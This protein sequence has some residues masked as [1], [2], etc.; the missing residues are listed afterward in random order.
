M[1]ETLGFF[2]PRDGEVTPFTEQ[3]LFEGIKNFQ[4]ENGLY[5]T[6]E[7]RPGDPTV[8]KLREQLAG[9]DSATGEAKEPLEASVGAGGT[10]NAVDLDTVKKS[11][12]RAG[13][14]ADTNFG[15][16]PKLNNAIRAFQANVGLIPDGVINPGSE[17]AELLADAAEVGQREQV[18]LRMSAGKAD[19][20]KPPKAEVRSETPSVGDGKRASDRQNEVN[21]ETAIQSRRTDDVGKRPEQLFRIF[22]LNQKRLHDLAPDQKEQLVGLLHEI[23]DA[24]KMTS[25]ELKALTSKIGGTLGRVDP[26][27]TKQLRLA[28]NETRNSTNLNNF[29]F[30]SSEEIEA[31][32]DDRLATSTIMGGITAGAGALKAIGRGA[33]VASSLAVLGLTAAQLGSIRAEQKAR[34]KMR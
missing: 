31:F 20:A 12:S 33:T 19:L 15:S 32:L 22:R 21:S 13:Q 24:D 1:L 17:T 26:R 23:R 8:L 2:E 5:P 16:G 18:P 7:L 27:L 3:G 9:R 25:D 29:R 10:N 11:L 34:K 14:L 6:G 4:G 28:L 30:K